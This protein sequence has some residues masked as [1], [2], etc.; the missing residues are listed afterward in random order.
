MRRVDS[1]TTTIV[2]TALIDLTTWFSLT[3]I[4]KYRFLSWNMH[5]ES[6]CAIWNVPPKPGLSTDTRLCGRMVCLCC[7]EVGAYP[8][9][10]GNICWMEGAEKHHKVACHQHF[11]S[12]C[13]DDFSFT[14]NRG[15]MAK[16]LGWWSNFLHN[17]SQMSRH[18]NVGCGHGDV[19]SGPTLIGR[20]FGT[21]Q[22]DADDYVV[23]TV[24]RPSRAEASA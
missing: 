20:R 17:M 18:S 9:N 22:I 24:Y 21:G 19:G 3:N 8:H 7:W 14:K 12:R 23:M 15:W 5:T 11:G 4:Q 1:N 16:M 10:S 6:M 13:C 2:I